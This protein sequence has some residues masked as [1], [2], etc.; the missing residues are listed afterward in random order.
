MPAQPARRD[1]A[2]AQRLDEAARVALERRHEPRRERRGEHRAP[3]GRGGEQ[4]VVVEQE[5][6][7][8]EREPDGGEL[9]RDAGRAASSSVVMSSGPSTGT[10]GPLQSTW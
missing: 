10:V 1:A 4:P 7:H 2:P 6:V 9:Q 8:R 3:A 5:R